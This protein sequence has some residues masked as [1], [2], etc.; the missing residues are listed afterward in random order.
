MKSEQQEIREGSS[1]YF[2]TIE[3]PRILALNESVI[4]RKC[5]GL[6]RAAA[7]FNRI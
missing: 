5:Q 7:A 2:S 6:P 3:V 1:V 4:E